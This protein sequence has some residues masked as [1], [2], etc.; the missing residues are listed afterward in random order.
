MI[1]FLF[2][3]IIAAIVLAFAFFQFKSVPLAKKMTIAGGGLAAAAVGITLQNGFAWYLTILAI[4][5]V[6]LAAAMVYMKLDEREEL[7]KKRE[8]EE[9]KERRQAEAKK[10]AQKAEPQKI[11]ATA[12][13]E[14]KI[15]IEKAPP[16]E[17]E[18][19]AEPQ[20]VSVRETVEERE[21]VPA[22]RTT[23]QPEKI[24]IRETI[25]VPDDE[26]MPKEPYGMQ[27]IQPVGKER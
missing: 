18:R 7:E 21:T 8:A 20:M 1:R 25:K 27:S 10:L 9:R 19:I 2:L 12:S 14:N 11:E 4:V 16:M 26:E 3:L 22:S 24:Q 17:P 13:T 6:S 5:A 15:D 23:M